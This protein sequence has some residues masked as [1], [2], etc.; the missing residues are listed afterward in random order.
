MTSLRLLPKNVIKLSSSCIRSQVS[1][2]AFST[3][4]SSHRLLRSSPRMHHVPI[5]LYPSI[6]RSMF[7]Q[8]ETTPNEDS[9]KFIP[10]VPVMGEEGTA[11]FLDTRAALASPLAVRLMGV[12]GVSTVFY[13]PDF[14]TVSKDS[15]NTWAIVKPEI[16]SLLMEHFSSGQPLF[17]SAE[18][19]EKAGPQDTRILDTDSETVAMIKELLET[20]VRPA[21]MEDGGDIEY[22]GFDENGAGMVK[23]K[24]KGSCRGCASSSVTLKSGIERMLMHYIPEVKGV[25][26]VLDPE[27]EISLSEFSKL[28]KRLSQEDSR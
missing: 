21:I 28:E 22:R 8:T 12:E 13:G 26:E 11:E 3:V 1:A 15:E 9:L 20:R 14:V 2:R 4:F 16:Y 25:E 10:G 23:V 19:R 5:T 24:L 17:R 18:E 7:I 6:K 27:E